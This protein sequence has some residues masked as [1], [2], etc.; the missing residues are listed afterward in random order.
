MSTEAI[1]PEH[2]TEPMSTYGQAEQ[3]QWSQPSVSFL[4]LRVGEDAYF[5]ADEAQVYVSSATAISL[6]D[7]EDLVALGEEMSRW[8]DAAADSFWALEDSLE[9]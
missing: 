5:S 7:T 8:T 6:P 2:S 4:T 9:G 1:V 3:E